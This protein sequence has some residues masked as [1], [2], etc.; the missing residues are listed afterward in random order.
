MS[1]TGN[2]AE[3]HQALRFSLYLLPSQSLDRA[4]MNLISVARDFFLP[5][6]GGT[7]RFGA[8]FAIVSQ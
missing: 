1:I 2:D 8:G 5:G 6:G 3:L 7:L 4:G